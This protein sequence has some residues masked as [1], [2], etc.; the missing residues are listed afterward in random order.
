MR[1]FPRAPNIAVGVLATLALA[2]FIAVVLD[3][4]TDRD[5]APLVGGSFA[6]IDDGGKTI[7]D[8]D[9]K[10]ETTLM[11]F[12]YTRCPD[13][14]PTTLFEIS[15]I[16]R[17]LPTGAKARALFVTVDPERD[18]PAVLK[19]YLSSFDNRIT[20]LTGNRAQIDPV[21][22]E[23]KVYSHKV[24]GDNGDY[25]MDH[26]AI[27]YLMNRDLRFIGPLNIEDQGMAIAQIAGAPR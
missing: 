22:K 20:G 17:K 25:T 10:G 9:Y 13:V 27:V 2:G 15:E 8:A 4:A 6:L 23:F 26:S 12:G 16:L 18:T 7:T 19:D 11:F 21:L 1:P 14:C 5:S 3:Y 24:P